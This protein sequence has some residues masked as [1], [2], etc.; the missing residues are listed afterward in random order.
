MLTQFQA[1][2]LGAVQ[3]IAEWLPISSEGINTLILM[4]AFKVDVAEAIPISIW[5]HLGTLFAAIVYFSKDLKSLISNKG[6][7]RFL[8]LATLVTG[9]VGYPLFAWGE[10]FAGIQTSLATA[11]IGAL[12]IVTGLLQKL[13]PTNDGE[14]RLISRIGGLDALVVGMMQGFAA[15]PGLSRSG[16]TVSALLLLGFKS[17]IAAEIGLTL[18]GSAPAMNSAS[19]VGLVTSFTLGLLSI[20]LLM[21]IAKRFGFWKFCVAVGLLSFL[22]LA[23]G[24]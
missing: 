8:V 20:G 17:D 11:G 12:L 4:N 13:A 5:L 6:F 10:S 18:L 23:L 7:L 14:Q 24:L 16:L 3:G 19:L 22:P 9:L 15:L 1:A 2:I 21:K